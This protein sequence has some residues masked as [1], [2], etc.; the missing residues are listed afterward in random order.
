[1]KS[2]D[3]NIKIDILQQDLTAAENKLKALSNKFGKIDLK[4]GVD[5]PSLNAA[6][7]KVMDRFSKIPLKFDLAAAEQ[8]LR[9][10]QMRVGGGGGAAGLGSVGAG[11]GLGFLASAF[12]NRSSPAG[13]NI[14]R[15]VL[16]GNRSVGG[17]GFSGRPL[18]QYE[19]TY[20]SHMMG[21]S[22]LSGL[23]AGGP[24]GSFTYNGPRNFTGGMA[25]SGIPYPAGM[26]K[27]I[28]GGLASSMGTYMTAGA[29]IGSM[30]MA[31]NYSYQRGMMSA[32][33]DGNIFGAQEKQLA[34]LQ[35]IPG[36]SYFDMIGGYPSWR[37]I[38]RSNIN[39]HPMM[40]NNIAQGKFYHANSQQN[41]ISGINNLKGRSSALGMSDSPDDLK[42]SLELA[43]TAR[44][45]E[46]NRD[47]TNIKQ[48]NKAFIE[49]Q[50]QY[51]VTKNTSIWTGLDKDGYKKD[52]QGLVNQYD[53]LTA[54]EKATEKAQNK[55][56]DQL[57]KAEKVA[58][59]RTIAGD[60]IARNSAEEVMGLQL[61]GNTHAAGLAGIS[62]NYNEQ[63]ARNPANAASYKRREALERAI[64]EKQR[65][66]ELAGEQINQIGTAG[67][68]ISSGFRLDALSASYNGKARDAMLAG[69]ESQ[70]AT[71]RTQGTQSWAEWQ[72]AKSQFAPGT[73]GYNS[74]RARY[75]LETNAA[76]MAMGEVDA[77]AK[78]DT[79]NLN[80]SEY[81]YGQGT[82]QIAAATKIQDLLNNN[83]FMDAS[84]AS[85]EA[86]I[87][88][89]IKAIDPDDPQAAERIAAIKAMGVSRVRGVRQLEGRAKMQGSFMQ[90][91]DEAAPGPNNSAAAN[92]AAERINANKSDPGTS[93]RDGPIAL[94]EPAMALLTRIAENT[95]GG[96][97]AG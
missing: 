87:D 48:R 66:N 6:V 20:G 77:Q 19:Q 62:G 47:L 25:H 18:G 65:A 29:A 12:M 94:A 85:V 54:Q 39:I 64:L 32:N 89:Q 42:Q 5:E 74:A 30:G 52:R 78:I 33:V 95:G 56:N 17:E 27:A 61:T 80:R 93:G 86:D 7:K 70:R 79:K 37:G 69:H 16:V 31:A 1:M 97:V 68:N 43:Q 46:G 41:V 96:A 45:A 53:M 9:Q 15:N 40:A 8:Q 73:N 59:G 11:A 23:M 58:L 3:V 63:S 81:L 91:G 92:S 10:L 60:E 76:T 84:M 72:R 44:R 35:A 90:F 82:K 2:Y 67:A 50:D 83:K 57:D 75:E 71:V 24:P 26:G 36:S 88:A 49:Q 22:N 51:L 4:F 28:M 14:S 38:D 13:Q 21:E 55:V 34:A